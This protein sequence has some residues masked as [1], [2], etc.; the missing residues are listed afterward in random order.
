MPPAD[1]T[2]LWDYSVQGIVNLLE[3]NTTA[4]LAEALSFCYHEEPDIRSIFMSIFTKALQRSVD[5]S[6]ADL[7]T[8]EERHS[9][10]CEV[11]FNV[12]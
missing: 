1:E 8:V 9:D 3:N 10:I 11:C 5:L 2:R 12:I 7:D 4:G 6:S